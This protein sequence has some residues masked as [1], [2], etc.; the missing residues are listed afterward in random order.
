M[1]VIGHHVGDGVGRGGEAGGERVDDAGVVRVGRPARGI[2][3]ELLR[4]ELLRLRR[5]RNLGHQ[6]GGRRDGLLDLRADGRSR[7]RRSS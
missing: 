4:V 1:R 2:R 3:D 6:L 5:R 7:R